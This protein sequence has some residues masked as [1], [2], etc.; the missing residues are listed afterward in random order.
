LCDVPLPNRQ[1]D[2]K[3]LTEIIASSEAKSP[4]DEFFWL[5]GRGRRAQWAV[6]KGDWKLLGNPTDKT[7][8]RNEPKLEPRFL[9]NLGADI[10]EA[11]NVAGDHPEVVEELEQIMQAKYNSI[12]EQQ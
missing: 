2:G 7:D 10:G 8:R 11:K 3:S 12:Y 6:R 5:L 1:F 4:H 9:V